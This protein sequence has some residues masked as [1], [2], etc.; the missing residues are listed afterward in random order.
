ME[1]YAELEATN[2]LFAARY[3]VWNSLNLTL[4]TG[5]R[6][7]EWDIKASTLLGDSTIQIT[8]D[9][10]STVLGLS[11]G[12]TWRFEN[13]FF[14][15]GDWIGYLVPLSSDDN[16]KTV[17]TGSTDEDLIEISEENKK[18]AED[19]SKIATVQLLMFNIGWIF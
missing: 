5:F 18:L 19:L 7:L 3:F 11:L 1:A 9:V 16:T 17:T 14:I 10:T 4:L 15:G 2:I 13:G 8:G 12:N 6:K